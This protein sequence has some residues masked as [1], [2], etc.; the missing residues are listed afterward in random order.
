M[1]SEG[2]WVAQ[3]SLLTTGTPTSIGTSGEL[4]PDD[5]V[6]H[7]ATVRIWPAPSNWGMPPEPS[8]ESIGAYSA[9]GESSF[10]RETSFWCVAEM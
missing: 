5:S 3:T 7:P 1:L 6:P 9:T 4:P 2:Y 8:R 10:R